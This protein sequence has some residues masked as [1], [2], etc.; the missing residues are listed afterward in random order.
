MR[1]VVAEPL[2]VTYSPAAHVVFATQGV[3]EFPS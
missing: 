2:L 1:F 3:A